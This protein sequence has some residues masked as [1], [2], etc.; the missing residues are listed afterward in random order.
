MCAMI[1]RH[2]SFDM[3][4]LERTVQDLLSPG[5]GILAADESLGTMKKRFAEHDI[6][7]SHENRRAYRELLFSTPGVSEFISGVI[8]YEETLEDKIA[9]GRTPFPKLLEKAG[10][11]PGIKV[12]QSTTEFPLFPGEK[13]TRGLDTL[14][15]RLQ[16]YKKLGARFTK[17]RAVIS[18]GN[19]MPTRAVIDANVRA[20]AMYA[21][22][23]V[24]AGLVPIL[25]PEVLMEGRH[26]MERCEHISVHVLEALFAE[27][28]KYRVPENAIL[29]KTHMIL[30]GTDSGEVATSEMIAHTTLR[31]LHKTV[32]PDVP[33]VVFLSGGQAPIEATERLNE[34][35]VQGKESGAPWT[36][37]YSYSRAL[38]VP[39]L[40][41]WHGQKAN[42]DTAQ[43]TFFHRAKLN[44]AAARGEYEPMMEL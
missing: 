38:E 9:G 39:V 1:I 18:I 2:M 6:Q 11:T 24:Q 5:K 21:S 7:D 10:I 12:D 15:D 25:E 32:P 31:V 42:K 35:V 41:A 17:W 44:S 20:L 30:P 3:R 33:G 23:A 37:T 43:G 19:W 14:P 8:L 34:I 16:E 36:L 27:L 40:D 26:S 13:Y 29:L 28:R 4:E 22:Y